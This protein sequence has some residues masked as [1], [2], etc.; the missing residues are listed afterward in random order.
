MSQQEFEPQQNE[1]PSY[2]YS[3]SVQEHEQESEARPYYWSTQPNTGNMP[4]N[5]HPANFEDSVSGL[6]PVPPYSYPAQDRVTQQSYTSARS[7]QQQ[8]RHFSPDGDAMEH[9]YRPYGSYNR[10]VPPWARPQGRNKGA[11]M[12]IFIVLGFMLLKPLL[13]LLGALLLLAGVALVGLFVVGGL[14][15]VTVLIVFGIMGR[16]PSFGMFRSPRQGRRWY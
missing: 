3:D 4:K 16:R 7:Q 2:I 13:A 9:G 12:L 11:R 6:P 14:A 15:L 5:E 1:R 8:R 10:S